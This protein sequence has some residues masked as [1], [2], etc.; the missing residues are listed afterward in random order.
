MRLR[1]QLALVTSHSKQITTYSFSLRLTQR[2]GGFG[3]GWV[4]RT[5]CPCGGRRA[6]GVRGARSKGRGV[7]GR[8]GR[9]CVRSEFTSHVL[10]TRPFLAGRVSFLKAAKQGPSTHRYGR[11]RRLAVT[12]FICTAANN[13]A[14]STRSERLLLFFIC[15]K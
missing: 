2:R 6:T 1:S 15:T 11:R 3:L 14:N 10:A 12:L 8:S 13:N 9:G 5:C 4:Y 7:G